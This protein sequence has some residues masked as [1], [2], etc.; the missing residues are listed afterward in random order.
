MIAETPDEHV[1]TESASAVATPVAVSINPLDDAT[2]A[3]PTVVDATTVAKTTSTVSPGIETKDTG[4]T[5]TVG[6]FPQKKKS[7]PL[8]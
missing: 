6:T 2:T 4:G 7:V 5:S 1:A 3:T 8:D